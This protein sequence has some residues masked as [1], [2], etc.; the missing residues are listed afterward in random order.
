MTAVGGGFWWI[1]ETSC[2]FH[3]ANSMVT[4]LFN[5]TFSALFSFP[6][7]LSRGGRMLNG[8]FNS[9][10]C[11]RIYSKLARSALDLRWS[12]SCC[13][14]PE[15]RFTDFWK[16]CHR[17]WLAW[18]SSSEYLLP[19]ITV[20]TASF[21]CR[22]DLVWTGSSRVTWTWLYGTRRV[23]SPWLRCTHSWQCCL[24]YWQVSHVPPPP[25]FVRPPAQGQ[26]EFTL[27]QVFWKK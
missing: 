7:E 5:I 2:S 20:K 27:S 26:T 23:S 9:P 15:T 19:V 24:R 21:T 11:Q 4:G 25:P 18:Y 22:S 6:A 16:A 13:V 8:S 14:C 17:C 1:A 3:S 10:L 12:L